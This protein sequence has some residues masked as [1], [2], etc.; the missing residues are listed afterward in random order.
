MRRWK[1]FVD[2]SLLFLF[3]GFDTWRETGGQTFFDG[4]YRCASIVRSTVSKTYESEARLTGGLDVKQMSVKLTWHGK[5]A[6]VLNIIFQKY[7]LS[8]NSVALTL[9]RTVSI[10]RSSESGEQTYRCRAVVELSVLSGW[11]IAHTVTTFPECGGSR[12]FSSPE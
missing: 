12:D 11:W 6:T 2:K 8:I 5:Y 10:C 7:L 3:V 9:T 4:K 1:N